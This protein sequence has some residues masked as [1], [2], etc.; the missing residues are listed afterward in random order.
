MKSL[1]LSSIFKEPLVL[2]TLLVTGSLCGCGDNSEEVSEV[3][4]Q[5]SSSEEKS[6]A[7]SA[8]SQSED[9]ET[10]NHDVTFLTYDDLPKEERI[11][12]NNDYCVTV[13]MPT[14]YE[15]YSNCISTK[16]YTGL[17][18]YYIA[19]CATELN[20]GADLEEAFLEFWNLDEDGGF[21]S[22]LRAVDKASYELVAPKMETV[23]L[24]NGMEAIRFSVVQPKDDYGTLYECPMYGYGV[25]CGDVPAIVCYMIA[26]PADFEGEEATEE[27]LVHFVDE[28]ANTLRLEEW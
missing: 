10:E 20:P 22:A 17:S 15:S 25:M 14:A 13:N 16:S 7:A 2:T 11:M 28:M 5:S 8:Q 12:V 23:T 21:H 19:A 9:K 27:E 26:D 1:R 3:T 6:A 18:Y 24:D 4:K